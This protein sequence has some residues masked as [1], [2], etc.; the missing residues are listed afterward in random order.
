[1]KIGQ[2]KEFHL[3]MATDALV[4]TSKG[5]KAISFLNLDK[6]N[7]VENYH[8]Y[9]DLPDTLDYNLIKKTTSLVVEFVRCLNVHE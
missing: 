2:L 8:W 5:F 1:G 9:T 4:P 6:R 3:R 7:I